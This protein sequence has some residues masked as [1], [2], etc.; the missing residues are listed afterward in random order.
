MLTKDPYL[1]DKDFRFIVQD[2]GPQL[3]N[4]FPIEERLAGL[5]PQERLSGL[6][7]EER[8]ADQA[9]EEIEAYLKRLR[10]ASS[11]NGKSANK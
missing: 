1:S 4:Y 5:A 10:L 11:S 2:I 3:I 6:S 7:L 8:L 9:P